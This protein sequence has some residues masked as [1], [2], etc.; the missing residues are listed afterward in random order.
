[1]RRFPSSVFLQFKFRFSAIQE[2]D[3]LVEK[4]RAIDS[5]TPELGDSQGINQMITIGDISISKINGNVGI[6][7][8]LYDGSIIYHARSG[9]IEF[10]YKYS[11]E[12]WLDHAAPQNRGWGPW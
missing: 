6:G 3:I 12:N 8:H 7:Q 11:F 9:G 10:S 1:M 4:P 5:F 2:N